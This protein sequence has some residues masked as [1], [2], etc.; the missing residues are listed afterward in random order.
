VSPSRLVDIDA[1]RWIY[2][3][4]ATVLP[5]VSTLAAHDEL[6]DGGE[7]AAAIMGR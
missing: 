4:A 1:D 6:P 3:G 2:R 7:A 5:V